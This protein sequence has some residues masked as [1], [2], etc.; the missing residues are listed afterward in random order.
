MY[1]H[2]SSIKE[3]RD[4]LC[5]PH[6]SQ[7]S[8][9]AAVI[10]DAASELEWYAEIVSK[11]QKENEA[12]EKLRNDAWAETNG[13]KTKVDDLQTEVKRLKVL[14]RYAYEM[15]MNEAG[16]YNENIVW[17]EKVKKILKG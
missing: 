6:I 17:V 7:N 2:D 1:L 14:L 8:T 11:L 15:P 9:V 16:N 12:L 5:N 10:E 3:L 4:V 13:L